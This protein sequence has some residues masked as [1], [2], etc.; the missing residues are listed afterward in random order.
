MTRESKRRFS[1]GAEYQGETGTHFRVWAP[2]R[3]VVS[4]V[5]RGNPRAH[6]AKS[7][8]LAQE[9]GGYHS[10]LIA[11]F[12][13]G[14]RYAFLLDDDPKPYPDPASRFQPDGPHGAA[15]IVD[16]TRFEWLDAGFELRSD[17]RVIYELHIGTFTAEGSYRSAIEKVQH[18]ADLGITMVELMPLNGFAGRFGWGYD[19]VNAWAPMQTYGEPDDLR[20][21]V[22]ALHRAGI[23]A[24]LD[25]VYNHFGSDGNYMAPFASEY[26]TDSYECEWGDAI[27]FDGPRSEAVRE[28]FCE[29]ARY[30]IEEF[31]F[32]GLRLDA[33][34]AIFDS[35]PRH[36]I[37]EIVQAARSGGAALNKCIFVVAENEPQHAKLA[38]SPERGGYGIDA[39][40]NDDFHHSAMVALTGK[41]PAYYNDYRGSA[42]ELISALKWGYLFQGQHYYWQKGKRGTPALD[43]NAE[44]YVTY[45]QNHDQVANSVTGERIDR[46]SGAAEVR[47]MTGLM[48][49]A[50]P[51]P[52]LFQ[53]Q[54]FAASCPFLFFTDLPEELA[55]TADRD[56]RKFLSQFPAAASDEG[57][58]HLT[59]FSAEETFERSKLDWSE[60]ERHAPVYRLHR[61][62][63]RLRAQDPAIRQRRTDLMH[64]SVLA[65]RALALRFFCADGD[66]LLI[67]NLGIDRELVPVAEPLLAPPEGYTWQVAWCSEEFEYGGAGFG[68]PWEDGRFVLPARSTL[69]FKPILKHRDST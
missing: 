66:R 12:Q 32:D 40:W 48:L 65:E 52:M 22:A 51:T 18:L 11:E 1:I 37:A 69:L 15:Q 19:G 57:Q 63:L 68:A 14:D 24:I 54:E 4:V 26:F 10:G 41:H 29:N 27:N 28:F 53:G 50:P 3:R 62:L 20:R 13:A 56:R 46:L 25:V 60:V 16:A 33:T 30:W 38:R 61:D 64:G 59:R 67:T 45:L 55:R 21:F 31:H 2:E 9:S 42:Q 39:L 8:P 44:H 43:L 36:V 58:R 5:P 6:Q 35:S 34:Q 17:T 7:Y 47:A 23:A 49:L